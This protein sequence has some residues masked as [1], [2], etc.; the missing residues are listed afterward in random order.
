MSKDPFL[1]PGWRTIFLTRNLDQPDAWWRWVEESG[2]A[3]QIDEVNVRYGGESRAFRVKLADEQG[4]ERTLYVKCQRNQRHRSLA[5]PIL[6]EPTLCNEFRMM[7]RCQ[8]QGIPAAVPLFFDSRKGA[9][10]HHD[11][12]LVTLGLDGFSSLDSINVGGLEPRRRHRLLADVAEVLALL[13]GKR[14]LHRNLYD[15]H[16]F[17]AWRPALERFDVCFIDLEKAHRVIRKKR[18]MRDLDSLARRSKGI[19]D[20]D[21]LRFLRYYLGSPRLGR[22]GRSM[23]RHLLDKW[24]ARKPKTLPSG[25]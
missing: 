5:H 21:K 2:Q 14:L 16:V 13:H 25:H 10:G 11:T 23:V 20:R 18:L 15:R 8:A 22:E 3:V 1:A 19:G 6:G 17:V 9:D 7:Q 4:V 12:L 24:S